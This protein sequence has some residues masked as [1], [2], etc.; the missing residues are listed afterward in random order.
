MKVKIT[1]IL[2]A[3][4]MADSSTEYFIDQETGELVFVNDYSMSSEEKEEIY[5]RLDE[6]GFYRLPTSFDIR[7]YDIIEDFVDRLSWPAHD[8][9]L[10]AISGRGAFSRFKSGIRSLGIEDQWY[11]F[12]EAAY[13]RKA[14]EWCEENG[15]EYD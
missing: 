2:D 5:D 15:I 4:E 7:D 6:H 13:G 14:V 3:M 1:D 9:L 8:R 11:V 10:A 12:K